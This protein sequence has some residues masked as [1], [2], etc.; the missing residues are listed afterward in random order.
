MGAR[1]PEDLRGLVTGAGPESQVVG[2]THRWK[3]RP[4]LSVVSIDRERPRGV[5]RPN[6]P[7]QTVL[8]TAST[9][10]DAR[11]S[12]PKQARY[13]LCSKEANPAPS[14]SSK[15]SFQEALNPYPRSSPSRSTP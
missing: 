11:E 13:V 9:P 5:P 4:H 12:L 14:A 8:K 10:T 3:C 2:S 1:T 15:V 6:W 7:I